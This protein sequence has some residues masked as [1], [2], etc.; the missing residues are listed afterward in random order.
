MVPGQ[1][2]S[3]GVHGSKNHCRG[4]P[5]FRE[6]G[7]DPLDFQCRALGFDAANF[8]LKATDSLAV[9]SSHT[10]EHLYHSDALSL[11][12]ECLRVLKPG[13]VCRMV[14]PDCKTVSGRY[15]HAR[16]AGDRA[17]GTRFMEEML[18]HDKQRRV[19]LLGTFQR[20]R[21]FDRHKWMYDADTLKDFEE[22]GFGE[23]TNPA[24]L[25]GRMC[26]LAEVEDRERIENGAGVV[27]EGI[28]CWQE[29]GTCESGNTA[30]PSIA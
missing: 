2:S 11:L 7:G 17:A 28:K 14:V 26:G 20:V 16:Q 1:F 12:K 23:V 24:A 25:T 27:A 15:L 18:V 21:A 9:Y 6:G 3:L 29:Y 8:R 10:L 13:G 4:W 30:T 19:G 5:A 22:A